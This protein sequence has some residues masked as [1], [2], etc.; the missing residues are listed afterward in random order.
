MEPGRLEGS[1]VSARFLVDLSRAILASE[2]N[3][4]PTIFKWWGRRP[5]ILVRGFLA[6]LAGVDEETAIKAAR[7]DPEAVRIVRKRAQGMKLIDPFS[8][9]GLIPLE[10]ARLGYEA[11]GQDVNPY[12]VAISR[13]LSDL[14]TGGC[15]AKAACLKRALEQA[16]PAIRGLWCNGVECIIHALL[17]RCPP[18]TAP[19]WVSSKRRGSRPVRALVIG[20]DGGLYWTSP[21]DLSPDDPVIDLPSNLP[22]EA[23]D[24]IVYAIEVLGP[25]K[26][27]RWISLVDSSIEALKWRK[28]LEETTRIAERISNSIGGVRIPLMEETRRLYRRNRMTTDRLYTWRQNA[29]YRYFLNRASTCAREAELLVA[30]ASLSTS[31]LALYYQPMA[32]VNPGMVVKSYWVPRNPVELNPFS[33]DRMPNP[34]GEDPRPVGRGTLISLLNSYASSCE[35]SDECSEPPSFFEGDSRVR[36]PGHGYHIVAT[37]P[38]Y[39][40]LH[41]YRDMSLFYA[42]A[43]HLAGEEASLDWSEIDTRDPGSY[44]RGVVG[45]LRISLSQSSDNAV[46]LLFISSPSV[47]GLSLIADILSEIEDA[48][49]GIMSVLPVVGEARGVFGRAMSKLVYVVLARK[50]SKTSGEALEPLKWTWRIVR[51]TGLSEREA[52]YGT[53][54][55]RIF[56]ELLSVK[57]KI[58]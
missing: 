51:S 45:S 35:A 49:A 56:Q 58:N 36:Q 34:P 11:V 41:T 33:H 16:W 46:L 10:A 48:G 6:L 27:R 32:K 7:E 47:E 38:P 40:G 39:P 9:S 5:R 21:S 22:R 2:A 30:T 14:C 25:G 8:G 3:R 20:D 37:D 54:L 1:P 18:C 24:Y 13:A 28:Y 50:G 23:E 53:K 44:K 19:R 17:A 42:H 4:R 12:A 29:T 26:R 55:S 57:L 15:M 31:L 43:K 52:E